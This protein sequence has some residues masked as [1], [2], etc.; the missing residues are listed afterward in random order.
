MPKILDGVQQ[1]EMQIGKAQAPHLALR[2]VGE[3]WLKIP[4]GA[5]LAV[6][7]DATQPDGIFA[8]RLT[9]V[10]RKGWEFACPCGRAGC[11]RKMRLPARYTG[12]HDGP[13]VVR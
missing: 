2:G 10:S 3:K 9:S 4:V 11:T 7:E 13:Q 6:V 8:W 1:T 12:R 5:Y